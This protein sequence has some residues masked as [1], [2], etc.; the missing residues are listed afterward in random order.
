MATIETQ[1]KSQPRLERAKADRLEARVT[2]EQKELLQ[3]AA[4][5]QGR[6]LTEFVVSSAQAE[7]ERVIRD[8]DV[9][10]L[11]VRDSQ[12]FAAIVLNPPAPNDRLRA[13]MRRHANEVEDEADG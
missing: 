8:R 5:L 9:I 12:A 7:A 11:S 4:H 3:R 6:T 2:A 1:K 13:A 10:L